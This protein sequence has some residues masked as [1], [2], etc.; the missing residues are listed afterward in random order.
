MQKF[1]VVSYDDNEQQWFWDY[2]AATTADKAVAMVCKDRPYV[3]NAEAST[4]QQVRDLVHTL[5]K[6]SLKQIVD[7]YRRRIKEA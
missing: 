5:E 6:L 7:N 2:V 4:L 3:I 1:L